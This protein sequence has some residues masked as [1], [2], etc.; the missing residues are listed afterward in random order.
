MHA[1]QLASP[2]HFLDFSNS[3]FDLSVL[4]VL[5][6]IVLLVKTS[7]VHS[8]FHIRI[9][10]GKSNSMVRASLSHT[11]VIYHLESAFYQTCTG[12]L[13]LNTPEI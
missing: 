11:N 4:L 8:R 10:F 3:V 7:H 5:T 2:L 12:L 13:I 6:I 1:R 9:A